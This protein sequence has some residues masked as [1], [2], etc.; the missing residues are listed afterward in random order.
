[1]KGRTRRSKKWELPPGSLVYVGETPTEPATMS[2]IRY[3]AS[4][5]KEQDIVTL[6]ECPVQPNKK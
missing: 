4:S 3:N 6:Y 5:A 2:L 1:M